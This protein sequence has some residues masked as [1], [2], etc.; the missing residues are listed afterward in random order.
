LS[1]N[2]VWGNSAGISGDINV[3]GYVDPARVKVSGNDFA[4]MTTPES[5]P[6]PDESNINA[7]P[8]FTTRDDLHLTE[9]SPCRDA[10]AGTHPLAGAFDID[11]DERQIGAA[12]DIG[13]D[14][15]A[16]VR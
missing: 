4:K 13:A 12:I 16:A 14:E 6:A 9:S 8:G 11:G 7:D 5:W 10:G 1:N 2:I 3:A 15:H